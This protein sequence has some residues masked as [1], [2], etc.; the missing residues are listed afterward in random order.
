MKASPLFS[1]IIPARNAASFLPSCLKALLDAGQPPGQIL[2][3][4]DGSS[5][6]TGG[7][8]GRAG[9]CVLK[10]DIGKGPMEPRFFGARAAP[11]EILVFVDA[12]VVVPSDVFDRLRVL[13]ADKTLHAV[14]GRLASSVE[15]DSFFTAFKKDYMH[16]LFARMPEEVDFLYGSFWAVRRESLTEFQPL[17]APFGSLV[18]DSEAGFRLAGAGK[19]VCLIHDIEVTHLKKYT[20]RSLLSNDFKIPFMFMRMMLRYNL[21]IR[22]GEA[23]RF[24]HA[25]IDQVLALSACCLSSLVLAV[26]LVTGKAVFLAG[27]L[28]L[29]AF[30]YRYWVP[31]LRFVF[32]KGGLTRTAGVMVLLPLDSLTMAAGMLSGFVFDIALRIMKMVRQKI[33]SKSFASGA[34][35]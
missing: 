9:V 8:A 25:G 15:G 32:H 12:D 16:T 17:T 21:R 35:R 11:G 6:D 24:S 4:N 23:I 34:A 29:A 19:R 13:F 14:T 7:A 26:W 30:Y 20:L 27:S 33:K 22:R 18:S 10:V 28:V 3:V 2:V 5:D 1:V 31:F